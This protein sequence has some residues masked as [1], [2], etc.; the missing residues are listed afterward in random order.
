MQRWNINAVRLVASTYGVL[1]GL[2]GLEHGFFEILQGNV[3]TGGIMIQAIGPAQRFWP[4]GGEPAMTLLPNFLITGILAMLVGCLVILWAAAFVQ[5]KYGGLVLIL[6]S[7]LQLLMGGGIMPIFLAVTGGIVATGINA[8]LTWWGAHFPVSMQRFLA[9]LFPWSYGIF[10]CIY[11]IA[12]EVAIIGYVPG[13]PDPLAFLWT[14]AYIMMAIFLFVAIA[15]LAYR[16]Q[17][18]VAGS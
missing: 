5:R 3:A 2:A 4:H 18:G 17:K 14:I 16:V 9:R 8:P 1:A 6:L 12:L 10:L 15:G 13:T 11:F 7:A